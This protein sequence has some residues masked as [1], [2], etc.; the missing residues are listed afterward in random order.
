[1]EEL[2][3]GDVYEVKAFREKLKQQYENDCYIIPPSGSKGEILC[4]SKLTE[5]IIRNFKEKPSTKENIIA[6]AGRLI[7]ADIQSFEVGIE[8]Y[9]NGEDIKAKEEENSWIPASLT[10]LMSYFISVPLKW[11]SISQCVRVCSPVSPTKRF[12]CST[13]IC[14]W[15]FPR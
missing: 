9:P 15:D 8:V 6:T 4:S 7:M 3:S 10:Q 14:S 12:N 2:S 13:A 5:I 11:V 1:M